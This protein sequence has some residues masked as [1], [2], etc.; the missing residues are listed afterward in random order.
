MDENKELPVLDF[1]KL[2][3]YIQKNTGYKEEIIQ[4]VLNLE[5]DYMVHLGIISYE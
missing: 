2:T 4:R 3:E 5:T 1:D